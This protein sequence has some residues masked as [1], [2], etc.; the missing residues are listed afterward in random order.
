MLVTEFRYWLHL[1]NVG[2]QR[3]CKKMMDVGDQNGQNCHQH[4]SSPTP[5]TDIDVT[6]VDFHVGLPLGKVGVK[7]IP[8]VMGCYRPTHVILCAQV[9][10]CRDDSNETDHQLDLNHQL[11]HD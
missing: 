9:C 8:L 3:L 1:F 11:D 2:A 4:I 6:D 7:K 5:V 10:S